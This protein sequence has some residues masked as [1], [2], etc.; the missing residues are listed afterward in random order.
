[1]S[2]EV[3]ARKW[4]PRR[5]DELVGQEHVVQALTNALDNDR[6]HHAY[7][8]TGTR[9]VGKTTRARIFAKSL[10]CELGVSSTPCGD[11]SSCRELD[12]GR[13]VDLIEVD[14]ASRTKVDQTREL[15]E[16]VPYAP[17]RGRYKVYLIDEVH[18]FSDS[19]FNALLKTLEE[20]P[21]HVK[22]LLATTDPQKV[23]MTVLSRCLQ[24]SL[25]RLAIDQ[26]SDQLVHILTA[27]G[28]VFERPPLELLARGADGSMRDAL[29]L[30]DQAIAFGGGAITD[31]DV[32]SM[33]G[34]VSRGFVLDLLDALA[35]RD[36]ARLLDVLDQAAENAPDYASILAEVLRTLHR[37]ALHQV[38][39]DAPTEDTADPE[40]L[41]RLAGLM[42]PEDVQLFYE[43]GIQGQRNLAYAPNPRSGLEMILLR[44][45]AFHPEEPASESGGAPQNGQSRAPAASVQQRPVAATDGADPSQGARQRPSTGA[46]PEDWGGL[47]AQMKLGGLASQLAAN[48]ILAGW[49]D[50]RLTLHL[51]PANQS[52]RTKMA[53]ERLEQAVGRAL[54]R[55]VQLEVEVLEVAKE[56]PAQ[57]ASRTKAERQRQAQDK[58]EKDPLVRAAADK[59]GARLVPDTV[60]PRD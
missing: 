21:A 17:A 4:R 46:D 16:N 10:T 9:G 34:T 29:S 35:A 1:M 6:L 33:L 25:K 39:P 3:L 22:F 23:P 42:Q 28:I 59:L 52:L 20:P 24:F 54:G 56:T 36:G 44:M 40:A 15:L 31:G 18:M 5:F 50:D 47:V 45:L 49:D 8:F 60:E 12:E 51:D 19:S 48:S 14:A 13:F 11:C 38:I 53:V 30:L 32:R 41:A 43:I 57:Q 27:E 26:I 2:Y 37:I 7:L 58:L 55:A